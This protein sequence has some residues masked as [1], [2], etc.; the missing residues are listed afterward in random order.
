MSNDSLYKSINEFPVDQNFKLQAAKIGIRTLNDVMR[1]TSS[2]LK[3]HPDFTFDWY[4]SLLTIL[5]KENLME[6]F[7]TRL[8]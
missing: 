7:Q 8:Y 1:M 3:S 5:E 2:K 6:V 4:K